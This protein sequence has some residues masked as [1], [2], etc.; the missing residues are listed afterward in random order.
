MPPNSNNCLSFVCNLGCRALMYGLTPDLSG[1]TRTNLRELRGVRQ[2]L[3]F[4]IR[5]ISCFL[6]VAMMVGFCYEYAIF[7]RMPVRS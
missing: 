1:K 6:I 2:V 5:G 3:Q 7:Y 4:L